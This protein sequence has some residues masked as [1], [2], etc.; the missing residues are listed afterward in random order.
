[1]RLTLVSIGKITNAGYKVIFHRTTCI[2]YNSKDKVMGKISAKNG[3]YHVDHEI[4]VNVTMAGEGQG[5]LTVKDL[6]HQMG[7]ITLEITKK[8]PSYTTKSQPSKPFV[9][10]EEN[11][12][13]QNS[14]NTYIH[15][16]QYKNLLYT[17]HLNIMRY[18]NISTGHSLN[19]H[20]PCFTP[21]SDQKICGEKQLIM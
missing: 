8:M 14:A 17:T 12:L 3:L 13:A 10:I 1:M 11:I 21:V 2:I 15:K 20:V 16:E 5:V 4:S 18:P 9:P 6:H 19:V 7:H